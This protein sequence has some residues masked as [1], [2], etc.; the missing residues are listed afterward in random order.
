MLASFWSG[1]GGEFAKQFAARVLTPAFVFWA[2]GLAVVWWHVHGARVR[3]RGWSVELADTA[4]PFTTL[5]AFGQAV[6]LIAAL[7]LIAGSAFV[8]ERITLPV[9]RLLE[10]YWTRPRWMWRLLVWNR[11]RTRQRLSHRRDELAPLHWRGGLSVRQYSELRRLEAAPH[12]D[13]A[14]LE[15]LRRARDAGRPADKLAELSRVR[16]LLHAMPEPGQPCMPTKLGNVLRSAERRPVDKYGL[17]PAVCWTALWLTLPPETKTE[18][19]Q[20]RTSLDSAIRSWFWTALFL[21]WTPWSWWAV[22]I[23]LLGPAL[24]YQFGILGAATLFGDL[25]V[26]AFDLHRMRLYEQLRLPVPES[27]VGEPRTGKRLID[28]LWGGLDEP[29]LRFTPSAGTAGTS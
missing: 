9:L 16:R 23:G 1:L 13:P 25:V 22:A 11:D 7:L 17:D 8:A 27:P 3:T 28:L 12:T 6:L 29:G 26:A 19:V 24:I 5:P 10:G 2:G 4:K 14:R 20:A 21:V 15:E 18:I